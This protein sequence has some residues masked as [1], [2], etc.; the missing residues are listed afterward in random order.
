MAMVENNP[1]MYKVYTSGSKWT[2]CYNYPILYPPKAFKSESY[3][4]DSA[5]EIQRLIRSILVWGWVLSIMAMCVLKSKY[6]MNASIFL[7]ILAFLACIINAIWSHLGG[8][9]H[10]T[11]DFKKINIDELNDDIRYYAP[12]PGFVYMV[13]IG[14]VYYAKYKNA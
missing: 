3:K 4:T 10:I 9:V 14:F 6:I 12:G 8:Y 13:I 5:K 7:Y 1:M 11:E 2:Y